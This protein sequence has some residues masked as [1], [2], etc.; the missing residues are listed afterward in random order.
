MDH[1]LKV[2]LG[3]AYLILGFALLILGM[4]RNEMGMLGLIG[5]ICA[6]VGA[7]FVV[8]RK[9]PLTGM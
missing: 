9:S 7:I 3:A 1:I 8:S 5:V 6:A 4:Y 2:I